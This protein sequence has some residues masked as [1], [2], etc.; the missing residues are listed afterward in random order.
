[1]L[2][3]SDRKLRATSAAPKLKVGVE[4]APAF[5]CTFRYGI[6][7]IDTASNSAKV[8]DVSRPF[9]GPVAPC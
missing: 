7:R 4:W 2:L 5:Q 1:M 6:P 8:R 3:S 9:P